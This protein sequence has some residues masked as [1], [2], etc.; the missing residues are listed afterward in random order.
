MRAMVQMCSVAPGPMLN[1]L[2]GTQPKIVLVIFV[3][4]SRIDFLSLL[5][6]V[7]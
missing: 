2:A 5:K 6:K 4:I 7:S 1:A 3:F